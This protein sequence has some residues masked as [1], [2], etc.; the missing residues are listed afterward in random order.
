M[1]R[2]CACDTELSL[3]RATSLVRRPKATPRE[4]RT[5]LFS[6]KSVTVRLSAVL[7]TPHPLRSLGWGLTTQGL[8][9]REERME[10][11]LEGS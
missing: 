5:D 8:L 3:R 10:T 11:W 6:I 4:R 2:P 9:E 1:G 7:V